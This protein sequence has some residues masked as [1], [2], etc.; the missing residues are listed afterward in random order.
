MGRTGAREGV[1]RRVKLALSPGTP[2]PVPHQSSIRNPSKQGTQRGRDNLGSHLRMACA[3]QPPY[4]LSGMPINTT[5]QLSQLPG[6]EN[7][8]GKVILEFFK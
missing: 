5:E 8:I 1:G 6:A 2:F 3:P 7:P 4:S